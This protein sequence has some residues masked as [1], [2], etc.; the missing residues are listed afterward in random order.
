MLPAGHECVRATSSCLFTS[1]AQA[2]S[3]H[4]VGRARSQLTMDDVEVYAKY[5]GSD[6]AHS[7]CLL[8]SCF[9]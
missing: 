7:L 9:A 5:T 4:G 8:F 6:A 1:G 2:R 3:D